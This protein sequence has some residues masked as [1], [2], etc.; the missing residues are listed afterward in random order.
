[1]KIIDQWSQD[2]TGW[3]RFSDDMTMR[4]RLGRSLTGRELAVTGTAGF[5]LTNDE[6]G[7]YVTG[8]RVTFLMLNP[9]TADA[10]KHDPT[11]GE[12]IKR[13]RQLG[14]NALEVVNL[15]A[16]RSPYP[17]DLRKRSHGQRG[18]DADANL[19]IL[20]ACSR[21]IMVIA[22]WG[23]GGA[24]DHRATVVCEML[25]E[26]GIKLHHL[27]LTQD[28]WPKHPLARGKHRIPAALMPQ[29]WSM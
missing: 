12:C 24:L 25:R 7:A 8:D 15:F 16:L 11:V 14:A 26:H 4:F 27:G 2:R 19:E 5:D 13:A 23:T 10:F 28:G 3:A 6:D 9:S 21:A 18:D 17:A 29:E 22:A 1:M 20:R